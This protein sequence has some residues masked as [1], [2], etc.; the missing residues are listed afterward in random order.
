MTNVH[1]TKTLKV[2]CMHCSKPP[3]ENRDVHEL[4]QICFDDIF[5]ILSV[6]IIPIAS[7]S[8]TKVNRLDMDINQE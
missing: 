6:S 7:I 8:Y 2:K 4:G 5:L 3:T 1:V